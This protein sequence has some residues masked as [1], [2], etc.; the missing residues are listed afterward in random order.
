MGHNFDI[1]YHRFY[2]LSHLPEV[3]QSFESIKIKNGNV[4]VKE[5]LFISP[6]QT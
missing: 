4:C 6:H 1:C 3:I 5:K 2:L